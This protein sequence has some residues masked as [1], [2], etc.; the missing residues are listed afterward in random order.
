MFGC[1][2]VCEALG[3]DL[4]QFQYTL[5]H[6]EAGGDRW[7]WQTLRESP[8]FTVINDAYNANPDSMKAS[9]ETFRQLTP[10]HQPQ[11]IAVIGWMNE[12][13]ELSD[14]YHLDLGLWLSSRVDDISGVIL[15][16][17]P[18][19]ITYNELSKA[20]SSCPIWYC[21][22][23]E[24]AAKTLWDHSAS[25]PE[26]AFLVWLK[27]S[28]SAQLEDCVTQLTQCMETHATSCP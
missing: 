13:G 4:G 22:T 6:F 25:H 26:Q 3:L 27:A 12:L 2:K 17:Q 19:K 28:R 9:Y 8:E 18:A 23:P 5:Q 11:K 15:V 7:Q 20:H 10:A 24:E 21:E 14:A 1:L 16:G